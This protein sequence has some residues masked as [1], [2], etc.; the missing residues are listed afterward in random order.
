M[1]RRRVN[2]VPVHLDPRGTRTLP[3]E[4]LRAILRGADEMIL[5][6]G[7]TLLVNVLRGSRVKD[8]EDRN[9][10]MIFLLLDRIQASGD[11]KYIP[12]LEAWQ[13]IDYKKVRQRIA[14]VI[15]HLQAG[16]K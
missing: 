16:G 7:R 5:R 13:W 2:R 15:K 3:I 12:L 1:S 14:V 6:G 11:G 8:A 10:W 9:R 4:D